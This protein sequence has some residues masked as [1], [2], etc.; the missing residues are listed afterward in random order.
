MWEG[1]DVSGFRVPR[2]VEILRN[3]ELLRIWE[4]HNVSGIGE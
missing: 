4:G 2:I 1:H 3:N